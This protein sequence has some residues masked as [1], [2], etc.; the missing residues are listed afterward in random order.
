MQIKTLSDEI[1][2]HTKKNM[3]IIYSWDSQQSLVA[4]I[5]TY[6]EKRLKTSF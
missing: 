5:R 1:L 4:L 2:T 6:T 3:N